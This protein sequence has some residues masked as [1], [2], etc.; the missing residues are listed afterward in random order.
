MPLPTIRSY[1]E[2]SSDNYGIHCMVVTLAG[3][4]VWYSYET[5]VAFQTCGQPRV[6]RTNDWGPTTGKHLNWIDN[7]DKA[8]RVDSARFAELWNELVEPLLVHEDDVPL[9]KILRAARASGLDV[10]KTLYDNA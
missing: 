4:T 2:Y 1:G 8:R 3:V 6:V 9:V 5:P 7:G 10:E